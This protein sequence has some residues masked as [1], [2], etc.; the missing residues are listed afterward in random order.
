MEGL[1]MIRQYLPTIAL[2]G[3]VICVVITFVAVPILQ[4]CNLPN[5]GFFWPTI[6]GLI[7]LW[8]WAR[9]IRKVKS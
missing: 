7:L 8:V 3:V 9:G 4:L 1:V 2:A 5:P 6:A